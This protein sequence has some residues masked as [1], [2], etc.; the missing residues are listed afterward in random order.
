M[1]EY[2]K[3]RTR[4]QM[5]KRW[6]TPE[7]V[8]KHAEIRKS[9]DVESI[10]SETGTP[11]YLYSLNRILQN[12]RRLHS[13]FAPLNADLHYSVKANGNLDILRALN[14][15]GAGFDCVSGGEIFRVLKAGAKADDI[16]FA[17]VGKTRDEITYA[18]RNGI[19]W[20]NVENLLELDYIDAAAESIGLESVRIALRF[21]PQVTASTHP[22]I[23]TGHGGA[24][25]G[26]T[27]DLIQNTLANAASYPRVNF[28][29][30]H[31]HIGS[32][33]ADTKA[34]LAALEKT[35][36]LIRPYPNLRTVN[37]GGGLPVVHRLDEDPPPV[38]DFVRALVPLLTDYEVMLE[39]GRSIV[40]DAG[41]LISEVLYVK[42]QAG[43]LFY[44]IDASMTELIR[45]ALYNAYHEILPLNQSDASPVIAQVVGPVCESTDVLARDRQL[46]PLQVGNKVAILTTGAY[47]MVMASNYNM[48]DPV[49]PKS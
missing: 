11:L 37:I 2:Q 48:P 7:W 39:P 5:S 23:A 41:L 24:K 10:V 30:V 9:L 34:T 17:G 22:H 26:L 15:A 47:G 1:G 38:Q 32:Q 19:G 21:N 4:Q 49:R 12:Y 3:P 27:A 40:A 28:A 13:A 16:V 42:K 43:Q 31:I 25:F 46:P 45:P 6:E 35:L 8:K 29:G 18:L 14:Q 36:S 33:L 20:L 44:V